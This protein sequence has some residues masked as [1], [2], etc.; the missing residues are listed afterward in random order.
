MDARFACGSMILFFLFTPMVARC[1]TMGV[2]KD[3]CFH[4]AGVGTIFRISDRV[5]PVILT[6]III[7]AT[8]P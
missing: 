3:G 7:T 1:A 5:T 6:H 8:S 2:N 4:P